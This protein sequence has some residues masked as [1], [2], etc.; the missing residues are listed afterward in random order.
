[1]CEK[2]Y[3]SKHAHHHQRRVYNSSA[4][5]FINSQMAQTFILEKASRK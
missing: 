3:I 1:M 2:E 5:F 4:V